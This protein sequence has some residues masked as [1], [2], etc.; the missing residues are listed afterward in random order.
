MTAAS[1]CLI[2]GKIFARINRQRGLQRLDISRVNAKRHIGQLAEHLDHLHQ[3]RRLIG[4]RHTGIDVQDGCTG[5]NL[6]QRIGFDRVKIAGL[7]LLLQLFAAG[8]VDA[9]T[10][11][12]RRLLT[13]EGNFL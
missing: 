12:R 8:G 13:A 2:N 6:R 1:Y 3:Q 10:D 5:F 7:E 11:N 9:L 4:A